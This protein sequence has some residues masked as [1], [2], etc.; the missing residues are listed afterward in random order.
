MFHTFC[1]FHSIYILQS[2]ASNAGHSGSP[3][4]PRFL[5]SNALQFA[6]SH[7]H[8]YAMICIHVSKRFR[9]LKQINMFSVIY[10]NVLK[11]SW[12]TE[13]LGLCDLVIDVLLCWPVF[14]LWLFVEEGEI[15]SYKTSPIVGW[16]EKLGHLPSPVESQLFRSHRRLFS[17]HLTPA[18]YFPDII[19]GSTTRPGIAVPRI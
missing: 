6:H 3:R 12:V 17:W 10:L 1:G 5:V 2:V 7:M 11:T 15:I 18:I 14:F 9:F 8:Q 13:V 19:C 4:T 16:C